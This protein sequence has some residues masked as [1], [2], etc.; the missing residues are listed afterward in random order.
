MIDIDAADMAEDATYRLLNGVVT[1]RAIAW[2]STLNEAGGVNLAPFSCFMYISPSPPLLA[3]SI[4][5]RHGT[6]DTLANARRVG[7]FTINSVHAPLARPMVDSSRRY[8]SGLSEADDLGIEVA[9]GCKVSVPRVAAALVSMECV[10]HQ[11]V[12]VDDSHHHSLLIGRVVCFRVADE[13][14]TGES[15]DMTKYRVLG[16]LGGR[17][18]MR[19]GE[20]ERMDP[21]QDER[22]TA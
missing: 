9:P 3:I 19:P 4:G 16:R 14:W 17:L 10:V 6:K 22:F 2:V 20:I 8:Q 1:P 15:L 21:T 12:P 11:V 7:E 18:Y 5:G 13:V